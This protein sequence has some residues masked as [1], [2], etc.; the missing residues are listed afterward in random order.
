MRLFHALV[1]DDIRQA[2]VDHYLSKN[3][4]ELDGKNSVDKPP[5]VEQ[6][7][8]DRM[9]DKDLYVDLTS[10]QICTLHLRMNLKQTLMI[11]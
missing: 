1:E 2:F 8:A 9:N 6:I 11:A 3:R 5:S 7:I 4:Q 10:Y